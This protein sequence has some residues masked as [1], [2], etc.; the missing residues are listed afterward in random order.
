MIL[1]I[2]ESL[3]G[4]LFLPSNVVLIENMSDIGTH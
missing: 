2:N 1:K 4:S 3:N